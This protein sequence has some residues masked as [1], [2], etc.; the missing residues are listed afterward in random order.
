[1]HTLLYT[2][3]LT[4]SLVT[5]FGEYSRA[6]QKISLILFYR[7][8]LRVL[9]G[10]FNLLSVGG[11]LGSSW[12]FPIMIGVAINNLEVNNFSPFA[13]FFGINV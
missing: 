13:S 8:Y 4:L 6:T 1:M 2:G 12:S 10:L 11:C 3:L 5:V 9:L 7:E